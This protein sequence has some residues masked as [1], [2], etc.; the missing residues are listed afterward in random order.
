[1]AFLQ[2]YHVTATSFWTGLSQVGCT[3]YPRNQ[4]AVSAL[5]TLWISLQDQIEADFVYTE[6][7]VYGVLGQTGHYPRQLPDQRLDGEY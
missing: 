7:D 2:R 6:S 1:M 5:A 4:A 3:H